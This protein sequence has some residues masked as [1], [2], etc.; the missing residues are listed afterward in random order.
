MSHVTCNAHKATAV[1]LLPMSSCRS[2]RRMRARTEE[3]PLY[4]LAAAAAAAA[5]ATGSL[6]DAA[7]MLCISAAQMC[8]AKRKV[9]GD[10][11]HL[12]WPVLLSPAGRGGTGSCDQRRERARPDE[13]QQRE[14]CC[15]VAATPAAAR[16]SQRCNPAAAR[17]LRATAPEIHRARLLAPALPRVLSLWR[18]QHAGCSAAPSS[19]GLQ[20]QRTSCYPRVQ[21]QKVS[22]LQLSMEGLGR[23]EAVEHPT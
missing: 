15:A 7:R 4:A 22:R 5:A 9:P 12:H 21:G 6:G 3:R 13:R 11:L 19:R 20:H 16:Q 1:A 10:A 17:W 18:L 23:G 8:E 14:E 2:G